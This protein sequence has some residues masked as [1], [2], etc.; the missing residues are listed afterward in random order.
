MTR[1]GRIVGKLG[2][3]CLIGLAASAC[4]NGSMNAP[5]DYQTYDG[6][7]SATGWTLSTCA[8]SASPLPGWLDCP[9]T[10]T[11]F[12]PKPV[13]SGVVSV[14]FNYPDSGTFYHGQQTVGAGAPGTVVVSVINQ[15]VPQCV[16]YNTRID[17][18]DGPQTG[19]TT[20]IGQ[21][22]VTIAPTCS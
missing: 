20:L 12:V 7:V 15:Y 3:I 1:Q 14:Y 8:K 16:T 11:V 21:R 4:A 5:T 22:L 6:T 13:K 18:Y 19:P 9:G 2:L 17:I 10:V